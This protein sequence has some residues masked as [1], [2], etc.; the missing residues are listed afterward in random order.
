VYSQAFQAGTTMVAT[1]RLSPD[2]LAMRVAFKLSAIGCT[3]R[4]AGTTSQRGTE[5]RGVGEGR[6]IGVSNRRR[7]RVFEALSCRCC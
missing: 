1:G 3:W 6:A 4:I 2:P 7:N 5:L